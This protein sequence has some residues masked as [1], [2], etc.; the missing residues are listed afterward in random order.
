M[1]SL[2]HLHSN[3]GLEVTDS[4]WSELYHGGLS[5]AK[6]AWKVTENTGSVVLH[7]LH[8]SDGPQSDG[9]GVSQF[10]HDHPQITKWSIDC[11]AATAG[12]FAGVFSSPFVGPGSI[13]VGAGVGAAVETGLHAAI[14]DQVTGKEAVRGAV[15]GGGAAL[16]W[17]LQAAVASRFGASIA[18]AAGSTIGRVAP[19]LE[20]HATAFLMP[21]E[22]SNVGRVA[23]FGINRL[24]GSMYS[25][26][27]TGATRT[28]T[29]AI[30]DGG[31]LFVGHSH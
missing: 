20:S 15:F 23:A 29:H 10:V 22:S 19:R 13:A 11:V 7:D 9:Y 18:N 27:S 4:W 21:V 28:L 25:R 17:P 14:G 16:A 8:I 12:G 2:E 1:S 3:D 31:D 30:Q 26:I 5:A 24:R 6:D